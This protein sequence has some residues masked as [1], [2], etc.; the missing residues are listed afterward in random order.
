M[1]ILTPL[2]KETS[3]FIRTT[4]AQRTVLTIGSGLLSIFDPHRDDMI[5]TFGELTSYRVL[6]EI[7]RKMLNDPEGALILRDKPFINSTIL[8]LNKLATYPEKSLGKEYVEYLKVNNISPDTRKPVRFV[9]DEE[10][11]YVVQRYREIHDFTHCILGLRTNM[12]GEVTVKIFEAIQLDLPMCWLA[13]IFGMLRLG[14]K[15]TKIYL[16]QNLPWIIQN[17]KQSK[18]L[19]NVYFEKYLEK[20]IDELRSDLNLTILP[21]KPSH[22]EFKENIN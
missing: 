9:E 2:R 1:K 16:D 8:D 10:K 18:P 3:S 20:N 22:K 6:P 15:H 17:A 14:P 12:L 11:A 5:S 13:G 4:L 19:I 21:S 7:H